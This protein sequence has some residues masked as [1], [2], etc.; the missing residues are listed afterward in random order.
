MTSDTASKLNALIDS[1]E[2]KV[3]ELTKLE[4]RTVVGSFEPAGGKPDGALTAT[5]PVHV[6][7]TNIDLL[8]GD[9]YTEIDE[10]F[11]TEERK[12]LVDMHLQREKQGGEIVRANVEALKSLWTLAGNLLK[13][14]TADGGQ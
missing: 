11:L 9:I 13:G 14:N 10:W 8:D 12:P 2:Q 4:I 6:L 3:S 1:I 5:G 7:H